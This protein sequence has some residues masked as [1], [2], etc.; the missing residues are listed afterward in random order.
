[1]TRKLDQPHDLEKA[2]FFQCKSSPLF[3]CRRN[4]AI[5][6]LSTQSASLVSFARALPMT[7][8]FSSKLDKEFAP[9]RG[10]RI[11]IG[12]AFFIS[13]FRFA[14]L[15]L[16]T[17]LRV[18]RLYV[19]AEYSR[20]DV[21]RYQADIDQHFSRLTFFT[22]VHPLRPRARFAYTYIK[23][24]TSSYIELFERRHVEFLNYSAPN[25]NIEQCCTTSPSQKTFSTPLFF[26]IFTQLNENVISYTFVASLFRNSTQFFKPPKIRRESMV[27]RFIF[28][29]RSRNTFDLLCRDLLFDE[30]KISQFSTRRFVTRE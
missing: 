14:N 8:R 4:Q 15:P 7:H 5:H 20:V 29:N 13:S 11:R 3:P 28:F 26:L 27:V 22:P 30:E 16:P 17:F 2:L 6:A 1:M 10:I 25:C 21:L 18:L 19:R 23:R 24:E 9:F 12:A